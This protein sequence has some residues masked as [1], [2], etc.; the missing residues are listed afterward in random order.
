MIPV[1]QVLQC[2]LALRHFTNADIP[3]QTRLSERSW[4]NFLQQ[5]GTNSANHP[6]NDNKINALRHS[7]SFA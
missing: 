4:Q 2:A 5:E 1:C 7:L 3:G 6:R